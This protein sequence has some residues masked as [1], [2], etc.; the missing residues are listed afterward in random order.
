MALKNTPPLNRSKS[1][2][3]RLNHNKITRNLLC[4]PPFH[5]KHHK[6][7]SNHS[8]LLRL[9]LRRFSHN[10]I[11][12]NPRQCHLLLFKLLTP[13]LMRIILAQQN[14]V[15]LVS[16]VIWIAFVVVVSS[17]KLQ[18]HACVAFEGIVITPLLAAVVPE[19]I[20]I[21]QLALEYVIA[22]FVPKPEPIAALPP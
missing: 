19:A 5:N 8:N 15:E 14:R 13:S 20:C 1:R 17:T 4:L 11:T 6:L 18:A 22:A 10:K 16:L 12:R 21:A 9:P 3:H 7:W 2:H